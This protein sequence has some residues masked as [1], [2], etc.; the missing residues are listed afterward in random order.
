L[1]PTFAFAGFSKT[2]SLISAFPYTVRSIFNAVSEISVTL[3]VALILV[4]LAGAF[5]GSAATGAAFVAVAAA[6]LSAAK[7]D[8]QKRKTRPTTNTIKRFIL[9]NL[10]EINFNAAVL[11]NKHATALISVK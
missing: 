3:P 10:L 7:A 8:A 6:G 9:N 1:S 5:T 11:R 2:N 4:T